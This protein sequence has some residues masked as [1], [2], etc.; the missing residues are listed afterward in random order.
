[1][2]GRARI[3]SARRK[4]LAGD[5]A[6]ARL[7]C[8]PS[9]RSAEAKERAGAHLILAACCRHDGDLKAM[10]AHA[11]EAVT[12]TPRDA[13]AHY[14]L[15]ECVDEMGDKSRA[16]AELRRAIEC[17][18]DMVQAHRYL[19]A[20]LLD[21][22]AADLAVETLQRAVALDPRHA[23]AWNNLGTA[24]HHANRLADAV[25]AYHRALA[26]KPD[27]PRAECN[28]AVLQRDQGRADLAEATLR[29]LIARPPPAAVFRPALTALA[30]LLRSRS[31]FDEAAELYLRAAKLA[32]DA[33]AHEMLDLGMVLTERGD[34][35]Q[36]KKAYTIALRQNP[37]YLRAALALNLT[38]PMIY[39]DAADVERARDEYVAGLETMERELD[40]RIAGSDS[41][42]VADGLIWSNF[43]LAYQGEDDRALQSRYAALAAR[44][45]DSTNRGWRAPMAAAPPE[46][47]KI[48]IGFVSALLREC[49]VG[50][51]FARW[52][53]DLD[54]DHFEVCLYSL[55]GG[56][57]E[58]TTAIAARAD[59]VHAFGGGDALPSTIAPIIRSERLDLLVYPELGM[60]QA[61][62]ALA[63]MRLAPRQYAAWGHPVTTGHATID[64]FFTCAA[65]EPDGGD[66]HYTEKLIRLPGIGTRF[67]RQTLPAPAERAAFS[68]PPDATLLLC[69][70][71]LFKIHPDNDAL[72]ARVLAANPRAMLV[73]FAG[74]HPAVTDQFMRRLARCFDQYGLPIRERTRV[75]PQLP[76]DD[77]LGVNLACDAMLD[78]LRWSGGQTSV[79]ALDC[80]LP[81]VTLPG[82]IMRGRQSA[83]MLS[84]MGLR[85]L[86][87]ADIDDYI[88][89]AT[90]LCQDPVW[91]AALAAS[92]RE[93]NATLF[94]DPAPL[95]ALEAFYREAASTPVS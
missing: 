59:R 44:A 60:G 33:S 20:L 65:M 86:I 26:L 23:E 31:E 42:Q 17:D 69:P 48:R 11:A 58:V 4:L 66:A 39:A 22:G 53:T 49:T 18:P 77:Y 55:S 5:F 34:P 19:G 57:D 15:A 8:D 68:L 80:G 40:E 67:R 46:G 93:R 50:R 37:R 35:L 54:R 94:D 14:A 47:R 89:I 87:A 16:I 84:L 88:R 41:R 1:M 90:R 12:E 29:A 51:Y 7:A 21:A 82:A 3:E 72:F 95:R 6:G 2:T 70:Q 74:R 85:E 24:L 76:H 78:T 75:L 91:R 71:S 28:L 32:P 43:Y 10:L 92:I 73:L 30:D 83:G 63:S 81:V 56:I 27:Y 52:L 38:L 13:L 64:G 62:F 61:T 9:L 36:A 79:D 45:L 25:P